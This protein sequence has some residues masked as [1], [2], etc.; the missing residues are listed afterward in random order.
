MRERTIEAIATRFSGR[1][2]QSSYND[3]AHVV[4]EEVDDVNGSIMVSHVASSIDL[5]FR[6]ELKP[7]SKGS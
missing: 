7:C 1:S 5:A 2:K 4:V 3:K 6:G